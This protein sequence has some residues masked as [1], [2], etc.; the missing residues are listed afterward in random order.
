MQ[1][2]E[3]IE[4]RDLILLRVSDDDFGSHRVCLNNRPSKD[5]SYP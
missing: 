2:Y 3:R 1:G 4:P 5:E